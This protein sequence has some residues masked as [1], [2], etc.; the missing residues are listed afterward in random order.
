MRYLYRNKS[1]AD[2]CGAGVSLVRAASSDV[3]P[4]DP[5]FAQ[6]VYDLELDPKE[7]NPQTT[8]SATMKFIRGG[9]ADEF[10]AFTEN[11]GEEDLSVQSRELTDEELE[12]LR[13]LGY[14]E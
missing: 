8:E 9:F 12:E 7:L 10:S 11:S 5:Q 1:M 13:A 6:H 2:M 4:E 3:R 14:V